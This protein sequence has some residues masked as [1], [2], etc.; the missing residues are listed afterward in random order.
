MASRPFVAGKIYERLEWTEVCRLHP[1]Q[2][3]VLVDIEWSNG[4]G[5][6]LRSASLVAHAESRAAVLDAARSVLDRR[7]DEFACLYTTRDIYWSRPS[8][9]PGGRL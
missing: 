9:L 3:V 1:E 8:G 4:K 6:E 5:A 7:S 2:W